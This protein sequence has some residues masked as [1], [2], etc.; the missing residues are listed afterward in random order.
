MGLKKVTT[1]IT[2]RLP[3]WCYCNM[4]GNMFGQ[5]TKEKCRFCVKEKGYYRCAMYN[6]VLETAS[7]TLVK[8]S[9]SC[10]MATAGFKSVVEDI[11]DTPE[12]PTLG[13]DEIMKMTIA[14]YDKVRNKL[15]SQGYPEF[16]AS[17]AAADYVL[18]GK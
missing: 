7:G 2:Y 12:V 11:E 9:R 8:K 17:K 3:D 10:E 16:M 5:P 6:D 1:E 4:Q 13:V 15:L 18:G 14:K